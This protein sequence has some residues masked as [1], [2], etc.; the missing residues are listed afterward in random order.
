MIVRFEEAF[1]KD[2]KKLKNRDLSPR[3]GHLID[4]IKEARSIGQIRGLKKL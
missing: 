2:L 1:E 4:L 3:I